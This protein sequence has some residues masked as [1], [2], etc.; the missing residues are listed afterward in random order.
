MEKTSIR[1][2]ALKERPHRNQCGRGIR[3]DSHGSSE[4]ISRPALSEEMIRLRGGGEGAGNVRYVEIPHSPLWTVTVNCQWHSSIT[5][6]RERGE[7]DITNGPITV[8]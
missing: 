2:R 1:Q 8:P 5:A 4:S 7:F 6:G 3:S